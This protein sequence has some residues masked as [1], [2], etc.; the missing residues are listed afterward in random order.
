MCTQKECV[1]RLG[2]RCR[3]RTDCSPNGKPAGVA[4]RRLTARVRRDHGI[5]DGTGGP[6][7]CPPRLNLLRP[8]RHSPK[9]T[10]LPP[11]PSAPSLGMWSTQLHKADTQIRSGIAGVLS[12]VGFRC[13]PHHDDNPPSPPPPRHTGVGAGGSGLELLLVPRGSLRA[14]RLREVRVRQGH[15]RHRQA[16]RVGGTAPTPSVGSSERGGRQDITIQTPI[17]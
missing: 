5:V 8:L 16:Q 10:P 17:R 15:L 12:G 14:L 4:D 1:K 7:V 9:A 3:R 2:E 11:S 13:P 6:R